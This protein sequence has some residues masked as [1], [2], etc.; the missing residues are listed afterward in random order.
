MNT[1]LWVIQGLLAAAFLMAG[2][3]KLVRPRAALAA[4]PMM[5]WAGDFTDAQVKGIGVAEVL[6]AIGLVV[7]WAT[8][9]DP[10]LTPIAAL[11]LDF[12]MGGAI[13]THARRK[14]SFVPPAVLGFLCV[15]VAVFRF[16]ELSRGPLA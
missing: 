8:G 16:V 6:G 4:N 11:G 9:I 5:G 14:E 2:M 7:P 10:V 3:M 12:I 15:V 1:V 13:A